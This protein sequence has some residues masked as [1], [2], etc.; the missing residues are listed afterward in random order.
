METGQVHDPELEGK[1]PVSRIQGHPLNPRCDFSGVNELAESIREHGGHPFNPILVRPLSDGYYQVLLGHTRLKAMKDVLGYK[2]LETGKDLIVREIDDQTAIRMMVDDNIKRWQYKPAEFVEALKL[3]LNVCGMSIRQVAEQ[4]SV[5][6]SWL[7]DVLS[8]SKLPDRVKAKV[9]WGKG[10]VADA[11]VPGQRGTAG[12][13]GVITVTHAKQ[14]ARLNSHD[15]QTKAALAVE[16]F[17]LTG[18]ET[19]E[20][21]NS[22]R[23]DPWSSVDDLVHTVRNNPSSAG[24]VNS[25]TVEITDSRVAEALNKAAKTTSRTP[26]E[27]V[28][29]KLVEGLVNDGFLS[30]KV[31][32]QDDC[33]RWM[34]D[35]I[36]ASQA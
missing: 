6:A 7:D 18:A 20:V 25:L 33:R 14:I 19:R 21:V 13:D 27:Y 28:S 26:E 35:E 2:E 1:I 31:S 23:K 17:G 3:L 11:F 34:E 32:Q 10:K 8:I 9:E 15:E 5:S 4:Y 30:E 16:K 22:I 29:T 36:L 24:V 12:R